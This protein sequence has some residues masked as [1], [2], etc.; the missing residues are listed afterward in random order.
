[1][2]RWLRHSRRREFRFLAF[3]LANLVCIGGYV[4]SGIGAAPEGSGGWRRIDFQAVESRIDAGDL[5][6]READWYH[7]L[8]EEDAPRP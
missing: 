7:A 1:M 8:T 6:R 4:A 2:E 5:V 3:M